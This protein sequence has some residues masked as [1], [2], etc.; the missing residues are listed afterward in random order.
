M[1]IQTKTTSRASVVLVQRVCMSCGEIE[2]TPD[3]RIIYW[4]TTDR[5]YDRHCPRCG[6][7]L[8]S[9]ERFTFYYQTEDDDSWPPPKHWGRPSNV[10]L[11]RRRL[12]KERLEREMQQLG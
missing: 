12:E 1:T 11:A 3:G 5:P 6:G 2:R 8:L 9:G 4:K 10:E 7:S